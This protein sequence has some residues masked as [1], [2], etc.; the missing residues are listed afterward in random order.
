MPRGGNFPDVWRI[1]SLMMKMKHAVSRIVAMLFVALPVAVGAMA[2]GVALVAPAE[3][4]SMIAA[5][6]ENS[7]LSIHP[8][9]VSQAGAATQPSPDEYSRPATQSDIRTVQDDIRTVEGD[10]RRVDERIGRLETQMDQMRAEMRAEMREIRQAMREDFRWL[11]AAII[12]LLG[13]PQL[14]NWVNR[15]RRNGKEPAAP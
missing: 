3:S 10:L 11:L 1:I 4:A 5:P 6:G 8:V 12:A 13:L 14:P 2:E 9:R 7:D 15:L